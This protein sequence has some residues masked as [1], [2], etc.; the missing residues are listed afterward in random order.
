M[1]LIIDLL[2]FDL[3]FATLGVAFGVV[4]LLT[5]SS[6]G[7]F[8]WLTPMLALHLSR[9]SFGS[10]LIGFA[11]SLSFIT[12]HFFF[13][14]GS[15]IVFLEDF[16]INQN[17]F[18]VFT[19]SLQI[20]NLLNT[21]VIGLVALIT[22]QMF[23]RGI[24][25][26]DYYHL[27]K[28]PIVLGIAGDSGTGKTTFSEALVKLFGENQA[29]ELVGD[30]YHNWDRSSPMWKTLTHLNPR[31]NNLFK[32]VS[33]LDKML[34]GEFVKVRSYN[35]ITGRFMSEIRQKGNQVILVS[36]LHALYPKQLVDIQDVSVFMEIE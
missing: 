4:I 24:R 30:D 11:F 10:Q 17:V 29:V 32:M 14:S 22:L 12:Y 26:S 2:N 21:F 13:S 5:P 20:K 19:N 16:F 3:L 34:D 1:Y 6:V 27:G 28:K 15:Q 23:S 18:E 25:G 35:H 33:D 9:S 7:W 31:A 8:L 36:G